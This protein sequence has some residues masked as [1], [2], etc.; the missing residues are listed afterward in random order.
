MMQ[1]PVPASSSISTVDLT[2]T[3]PPDHIVVMCKELFTLATN[4]MT[5]CAQLDHTNYKDVESYTTD[6]EMRWAKAVA[7][8]DQVNKMMGSK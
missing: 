5:Q 7:L 3:P 6:F 4:I 2:T 8:I 1:F